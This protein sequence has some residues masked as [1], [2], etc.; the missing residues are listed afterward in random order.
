LNAQVSTVLTEGIYFVAV[1]NFNA[2]PDVL[3]NELEV[4]C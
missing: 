2:F 3:E 4:T 1:T